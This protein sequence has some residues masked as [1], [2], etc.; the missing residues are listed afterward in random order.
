[1]EAFCLEREIPFEICGKVIV[2][3]NASELPLLENLYQRGLQNGVRCEKISTSRLRE[4]EPHASGLEA[5]HVLETGIVDYKL[6]AMKLKEWLLHRGVT[7]NTGAE[8]VGVHVNSDHV[9]L[10]VGSKG[11]WSAS[12]VIN[13]GGLQSDRI[14]QLAGAKTSVRIIP[15]RGDY[16]QLKPE[17]RHLCRGLIYPT[18]D[19]KF[20][21]LGV[22]FTRMMNGHVECG[23]N[24]VLSLAREGYGKLDFRLKDMAASFSHGGFLKLAMEHWRTGVGEIWRGLSK[25]AFT[26]SLQKLIPEIQEADLLPAPSGIRAQAVTSDGALADDFLIDRQGRMTH[27]LN[28]PSPAATSSLN[29]AKLIADRIEE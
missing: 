11:E 9:R 3:T 22:H 16:Y 20:P 6:V 4:I 26:R 28:A 13:C 8:V 21:F 2:A 17:R 23:P 10:D 27:V 18:P 5:I 29:I 7:V 14:A 24:A 1:M 25:S 19:P 15:F 12:H